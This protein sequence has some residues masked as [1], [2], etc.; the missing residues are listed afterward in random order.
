MGHIIA[1]FCPHFLASGELLRFLFMLSIETIQIDMNSQL[2][3]Q[4]D[5]LIEWTKKICFK[6]PC[7]LFSTGSCT[8]WLRPVNTSTGPLPGQD[9]HIEHSFCFVPSMNRNSQCGPEFVA[10]AGP[11]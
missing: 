8:K 6:G 9:T 4:E 2:T 5:F 3:A 11:K 7:S 10:Q 1:S